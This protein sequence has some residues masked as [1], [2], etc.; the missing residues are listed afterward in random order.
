MKGVYSHS[1]A[2][3]RFALDLLF[4]TPVHH[5]FS[6][7]TSKGEEQLSQLLRMRAQAQSKAQRAFCHGPW[8][9]AVVYQREEFQLLHRSPLLLLLNT[10]PQHT[11]STGLSLPKAARARE[12]CSVI[13]ISATAHQRTFWRII[14]ICVLTTPLEFH[15]HCSTKQSATQPALTLQESQHVQAG[16]AL[17]DTL[18]A[19]D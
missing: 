15:S 4:I 17:T 6:S 19:K 7:Q 10:N 11:H 13:S 3:H 8:L 2:L 5:V 1:K 16:R 14:D 18:A 9:F 12:S